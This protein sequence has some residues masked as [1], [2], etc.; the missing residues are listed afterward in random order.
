M[1]HQL[2]A[3][4]RLVLEK[5]KIIA[6]EMG[7]GK[8]LVGIHY[9][10]SCQ[11][12][13]AALIIVPANKMSDWLCDYKSWFPEVTVNI[14]KPDELQ[15][16]EGA[17]K[18]V[19]KKQRVEEEEPNKKPRKKKLQIK[20]PVAKVWITSFTKL[21]RSQYAYQV[22]ERQFDIVVVDEAHA[23]KGADAKC[24]QKIVPVI[25]NIPRVA[26]LTGT[27]M[28]NKPSEL[29]NLLHMMDP[30]EFHSRRKFTKEYCDGKYNSWGAWEEKGAKNLDK[31]NTI[32]SKYMIRALKSEVMPD[33]PPKT[34]EIKKFTGVT[35]ELIECRSK[36]RDLIQ[37]LTTATG[38]KK[39]QLSRQV[40]IATSEYWRLT[41]RVKIPIIVPW[42]IKECTEEHPEA[43]FMIW[44]WHICNAEAL[45]TALTEAGINC[46][47][48]T[49]ENTSPLSRS[50]AFNPI[51]DPDSPTRIC[52]CTIQ[53]GGTGYTIVPGPSRVIFAEMYYV[54]FLLEQT[55]DRVHRKG[56]IHPIHITYCA[57]TGSYDDPLLEKISYKKKL[58]DKI[59]GGT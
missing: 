36:W 21:T 41:G 57:L 15:L 55:E 39:K 58:F 52:I 49:G 43:K 33:L 54:P 17:R 46:I 56:T 37:K 27:P 16:P 59:V 10:E 9:I 26:L 48:V 51:R 34:R 18:S 8:T 30:V 42:I 13:S 2:D 12:I 20:K 35:P 50:D 38:L 4:D 25:S 5:R 47:L 11:D 22:L 6:M 19:I 7:C 24:V 44:C 40:E 53:A 23:L 45:F 28:M 3:I 31:L 14:W 1:P 29:F 32:L